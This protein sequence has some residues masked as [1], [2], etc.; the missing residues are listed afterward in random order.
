MSRARRFGASAFGALVVAILAIGTGLALAPGAA[1][2]APAPEFS[3]DFSGL[4][5]GVP[6]TETGGFTLD[7]AADL[8]AF[9]WLARAGVL[10]SA[11]IID[12]EVCDSAGNCVDPRTIAGSVP[13]AAGA[14]TVTVP[15]EL[16]AAA[17]NGQTGTAVGRLTFQA[18]D[19]LAATGF[20]AAPWIA[21]GIAVIAVGAL[22]VALVRRRDDPG[23][24]QSG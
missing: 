1:N 13:F 22:L 18:N 9:D 15:V 23:E 11:V 2:A 3:L 20:P 16:P 10:A 14:A 7:R 6:Q 24:G 19:D 21:G 5:P 8:V 17:G 4:Q 12:I